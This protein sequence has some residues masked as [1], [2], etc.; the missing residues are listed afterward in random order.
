[1]IYTWFYPSPIGGVALAEEEGA[2]IGAWFSGQKYYGST[3]KNVP[4][5]EKFTPLLQE[6]VLWL[7]AYFAGQV[8]KNLPRLSLRG[9]AFQ[10]Q[11]WELL[12]QIPYGE[13][14]TYGDL[15]KE[16]CRVYHQPNMSAQAVGHAVSCN[17]I[18]IL[19]PCHRVVG[20]KGQLTG[21]AGGVERKRAL[22]EW[23][24]ALL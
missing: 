24:G 7:Q 21:Y 15:A 9:T 16:W 22:L 20:A 11:V 10:Q 17:P 3:I 5:R 8:P 4:S 12:L 23:E 19:V 14:V 18:S 13:T 6:T 2:L 1:M